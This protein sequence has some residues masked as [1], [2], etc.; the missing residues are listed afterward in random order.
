MAQRSQGV[1]SIPTVRLRL[2][3]VLIKIRR[4]CMNT[5]INCSM[6]VLTKTPPNNGFDF[7]VVPP[8]EC[9]ATLHI[10]LIKGIVSEAIL[11]ACAELVNWAWNTDGTSNRDGTPGGWIGTNAM[12]DAPKYFSAI[13]LAVADQISAE[14]VGVKEYADGTPP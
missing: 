12:K 14:T 3:K 10:E 8:S 11:Q 7:T 9:E 5:C 13:R 6:E 1:G 2:Y 4:G